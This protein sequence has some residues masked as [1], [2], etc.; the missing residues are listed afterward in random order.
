M[1]QSIYFVI[2]GSISYSSF[3]ECNKVNL[4]TN[5]VGIPTSNFINAL[6]RKLG[7]LGELFVSTVYLKERRILGM[8]M[9]RLQ[10]NLG[11]MQNLYEIVKTVQMVV[12]VEPVRVPK[13][14]VVAEFDGYCEGEVIKV[15]L[16]GNQQPILTE[17]YKDAHQKNVLGMKESMSDL[18]QSLGM[19]QGLSERLK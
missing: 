18:A 5:L 10:R 11:N 4:K 2:T 9:M 15:T 7:M 8:V 6:V 14:L 16:S 3:F 13:E 17:A 1:N 12:Q 19:P